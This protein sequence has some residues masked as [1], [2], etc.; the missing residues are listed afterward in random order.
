MI[1]EIAAQNRATFDARDTAMWL[2]MGQPE[3]ERVADGRAVT[4]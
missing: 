1:V 3:P 4:E 2:L